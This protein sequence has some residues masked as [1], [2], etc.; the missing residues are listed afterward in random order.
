[1]GSILAIFL[2]VFV[3]IL[4]ASEWDNEDT[5]GKLGSLGCLVYFV[6]GA[7][8]LSLLIAALYIGALLIVVVLIALVYGFVC[9]GVYLLLNLL[10]KR[11][12]RALK[13]IS[14]NIRFRL[15]PDYNSL[16][17]EDTAKRSLRHL[18][19]AL[20]TLT[21]LLI[22]ALHFGLSRIL[23]TTGTYEGNGEDIQLYLLLPL[24]IGV[25]LFV[26]FCASHLISICPKI[27]RTIDFW[28]AISNY[29]CE[30]SELLQRFRSVD[31]Q[32]V[33]ICTELEVSLSPESATT[34][35]SLSDFIH[36]TAVSEAT[37]TVRSDL[38]RRESLLLALSDARNVYL[39]NVSLLEK[40][41]L[42]AGKSGIHKLS[43]KVNELHSNILQTKDI[44]LIELDFDTFRE[45]MEVFAIELN[46]ILDQ[47]KTYNTNTNGSQA[48]DL[49]PYEVLGASE[50]QSLEEIN[51]IYK[52]LS[53]VYHPDMGKVRDAKKFREITEAYNNIKQS[54]T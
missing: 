52:G 15:H 6:I 46:E 20:V 48:K 22:L 51:A 9:M 34:T 30:R 38:D 31:H 42:F 16:I 11:N 45:A 19:V 36:S 10:I 5:L 26:Y 4:V 40:A 13:P 44:C 29:V 39:N 12:I 32:I 53:K 18:Q 17:F 21:G 27:V 1:M 37:H 7:I 14:H 8:A 25:A 28:P 3:G 33:N 47:P 49:D 23:I 35:L 50:D 43:E 24:F 41:A 2:C 54:K